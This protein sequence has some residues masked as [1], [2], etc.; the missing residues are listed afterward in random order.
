MMEE[1][2]L[3]MATEQREISLALLVVGVVGVGGS[4]LSFCRGSTERIS[5]DSNPVKHTVTAFVSCVLSGT[6]AE[7]H[8]EEMCEERE[9]ERA[10]QM[11]A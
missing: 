11:C 9:R 2:R 5:D 4:P 7:E 1:D 8:N 6:S 3:P 10:A